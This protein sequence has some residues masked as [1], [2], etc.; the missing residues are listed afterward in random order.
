M[1]DLDVVLAAILLFS[2][3]VYTFFKIQ[4]INVHY[5]MCLCICTKESSKSK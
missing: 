5:R 2:F 3:L 1:L 4:N